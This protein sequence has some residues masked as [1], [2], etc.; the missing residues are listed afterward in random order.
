[1]MMTMR[2]NPSLR[3]LTLSLAL[4]LTLALALALTLVL[5]LIRTLTLSLT[6]ALILP[7][8]LGHDDQA[9]ALVLVRP[10]EGVVRGDLG[11]HTIGTSNSQCPHGSQMHCDDRGWLY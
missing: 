7:S 3:T 11:H 2:M 9:L 10:V 5:A 8:F 4:A 6:L 1:M